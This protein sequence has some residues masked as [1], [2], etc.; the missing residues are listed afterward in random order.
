MPVEV[1]LE[2][3]KINR[4]VLTES[5]DALDRIKR[6]LLPPSKKKNHLPNATNIRPL[7]PTEDALPALYGL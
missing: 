5:G 7:D 4:P 2:S 1:G 6:I 3:S